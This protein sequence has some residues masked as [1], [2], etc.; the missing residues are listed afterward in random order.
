MAYIRL[1]ITEEEFAEY[2]ALRASTP[3]RRDLLTQAFF[4][5]GMDGMRAAKER[6]LA[7]TAKIEQIQEVLH[8]PSGS[9]LSDGALP[10]PEPVSAP[11]APQVT[12]AK[13]LVPALVDTFMQGDCRW[14]DMHGVCDLLRVSKQALCS[15]I[16]EV[17]DILSYQGKKWIDTRGLRIA[18]TMS[19]ND[20]ATNR[21]REWVEQL[22][23]TK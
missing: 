10:S 11:A 13:S 3:V 22:E 8:D 20:D 14:F 9:F 7:V 17:D 6:I 4:R 19:S 1:Q 12:Q 18:M 16:D 23:N 5:A 21:L 15:D 2:K